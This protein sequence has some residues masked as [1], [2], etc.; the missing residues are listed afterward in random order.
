MHTQPYNVLLWNLETAYEFY[1]KTD[2]CLKD[3]T[4]DFHNSLLVAINIVRNMS[5]CSPIDIPCNA[6]THPFFSMEH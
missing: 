4:G 6:L 2:I 3:L 1:Q 5:G